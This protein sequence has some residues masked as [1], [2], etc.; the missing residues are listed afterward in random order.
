MGIAILLSH[1]LLDAWWPATSS[2]LDERWPL[3]V[4]AHAQMAGRGGT[5]PV[6]SHVIL[7]HSLSVLLG[8][9]QG[10]D[11]RQMLTLFRFYPPD[12]GVALAGVYLVWLLV[13]VLLYPFCRWIAGV[14]ARRRDWWLS[15][16]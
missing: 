7:I 14:K 16:V 4:A 10:F 15:Y 6:R 11:A 13:I 9:A 5:V 3:W 8:M 1:N 12:Y 2:P